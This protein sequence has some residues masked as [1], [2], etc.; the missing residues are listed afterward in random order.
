ML[1]RGQKLVRLSKDKPAIFQKR[2]KSET[3]HKQLSNLM[4]IW[5]TKVILFMAIKPKEWEIQISLNSNLVSTSLGDSS[6]KMVSTKWKTFKRGINLLCNIYSWK[7]RENRWRRILERLMTLLTQLCT[8]LWV[9]NQNSKTHRQLTLYQT[10][11]RK[12]IAMTTVII[13]GLNRPWCR[14]NIRVC[15]KRHLI[16]QEIC[17]S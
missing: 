10:W 16:L 6:I 15:R 11:L 14:L 9:A 1:I 7:K 8:R 3:S 4:I 17:R 13:R 2:T 5:P 12:W